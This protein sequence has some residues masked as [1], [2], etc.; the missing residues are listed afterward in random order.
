[1]F[2]YTALGD[3]ITAGVGATSPCRT[4]PARVLRDV[5]K[6]RAGAAYGDVLAESGWTTADLTAAVLEN[7]GSYLARSNVV[8]I[9]VGG[10]DLVNAALAALNAGTRAALAAQLATRLRVH[11]AQLEFLIRHIHRVSRAGIVVCTQ[12]NPFPNT[13]LAAEAVEKLNQA[14]IAAAQRAG[15]AVAPV[16]AWFDGHQ[17]QWIAGYRTGRLQDALRGPAPVHPNDRGCAA[18]AAGLTPILSGVAR[19]AINL[20]G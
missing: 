16:D 4:Y 7:P 13:P 11:E 1:M 8:S 17:A 2:Q 12:Y 10:D 9:W 20:Y 14:T 5:R 6:L 19:P 18:I 15:A 3:S